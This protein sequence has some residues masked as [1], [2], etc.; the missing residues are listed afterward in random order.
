MVTVLGNFT[1]YCITF[2]ICNPVTLSLLECDGKWMCVN[3]GGGLVVIRV[4]E[5]EIQ[6]ESKRDRERV[7]E[8]EVML[9][10]K[11]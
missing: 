5:R 3:W 8:R 1:K 10:N 6:K 11:S 7:G 9:S 2:L 4:R